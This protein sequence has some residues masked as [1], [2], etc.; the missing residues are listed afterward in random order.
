MSITLDQHEILI[1]TAS[2]VDLVFDKTSNVETIFTRN[3]LKYTTIDTAEMTQPEIDTFV[4]T[5]GISKIKQ[6][7]LP[8]IFINKKKY[9][10]AAI[11]QMNSMKTVDVECRK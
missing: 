8:L 4:R 9:D 3:N 7:N 6:T 2:N 11:I 10:F 1:L 5:N